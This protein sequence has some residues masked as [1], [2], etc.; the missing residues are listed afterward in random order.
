MPAQLCSKEEDGL[1]GSAPTDHT[2][3][4]AMTLLVWLKCQVADPFPAAKQS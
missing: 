2:S 4:A 3:R 1:H